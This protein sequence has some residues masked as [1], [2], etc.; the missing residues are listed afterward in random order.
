MYRFL[1]RPK[2]IA[3]TLL[4]ILLVILMVNLGFWQLRRL[5]ERKD[6]NSSLA[7]RESQPIAELEALVT[8]G[9]DPESIEWRAVRV[10]GAYVADEQVLIVNRSQ[11]GSAGRSVVTP[12]RLSDG[13]LVLV[14]RG[15]VPET[16]TVPLPPS[17]TVVVDG[18]VRDSEVRRTGQVSDSDGERLEFQRVDIDRIAQQLDG[19]VIPVFVE[20]TSSEP[21][22]GDLPAPVPSPDRDEGPHLSYAIQWFIFSVCAVVGWVL[23]VRRSSRPAAAARPTART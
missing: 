13:R 4:V 5:D 18:R 6:F 8:E 15:F 23:A 3:F 9:V 11:S 17:G 21:S 16:A 12:L 22:Q 19:D 10:T 7:A 14:N 2:W 20:L 1:L